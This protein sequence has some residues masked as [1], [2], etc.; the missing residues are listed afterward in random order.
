MTMRVA[1]LTTP[2]GAFVSHHLIKHLHVVGV[3][4]DV[5]SWVTPPPLSRL[6][7]VERLYLRQGLRG[8]LVSLLAKATG[9]RRATG[10]ADRARAAEARTAVPL[11]QFPTWADIHNHY[12]I[13]VV[14]VDDINSAHAVNTVAAW[15]P[16]L[17]IV[18]G[19][20][21]LKGPILSVARSGVLNKHSS[22]LPR[23]RGLAAEYWCLYHEDFDALGVTVH[24]VAPGLDAGAIVLQRPLEFRKGDTPDT[25]RHRSELLGRDLLVEAVRL[26]EATGCTGTPQDE[27]RASRNPR[28][29]LITDRTLYGKLP[30]LWEKY[31]R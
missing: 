17:C 2:Q 22:L 6:E 28:P 20:R 7:R 26:I 19:G 14:D 23:H 12:D 13:P 31:G 9:G 5:G 3:V 24:Y 30:H 15:Q 4:V 11:K 16:D 25:L 10:P 21:V 27:S 8:V 29:T 1:L 18:V